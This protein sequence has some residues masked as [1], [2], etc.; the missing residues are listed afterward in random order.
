MEPF[1]QIEQMSQRTGLSAHTL[2]Y[3]ER[4][5]LIEPVHRAP[6][7]QRLY[8]ATD[9]RWIEFLLRL[10]NTGMPIRQMLAYAALRSQGD[11]TLVERRHLLQSHLGEIETQ[12]LELQQTADYLREKIAIYHQQESRHAIS[13]Q[14]NSHEHHQ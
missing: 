4:I 8:T 6:G 10:R 9:L 7:G 3:Y 13:A 12:L 14:G 2:R 1:L 5:G 11:D